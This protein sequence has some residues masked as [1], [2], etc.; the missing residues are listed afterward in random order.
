[1]LLKSDLLLLPGKKHMMLY[2]YSIFAL[3]L[4]AVI[5]YLAT[6]WIIY[7]PAVSTYHDSKQILKLETSGG[8]VI[9]AIYLPKQGSS[10]TVLMSHGNAEDL[11]SIYGVL[12]EW[13]YRDF[14]VFVYDYPGYGTSSG[15]TTEKSVYQAAHAA[16]LYLTKTLDIPANRIIIY[17]RSIGAAIATQLALTH[18]SAALILESPFV[19]A[20]RVVTK[21]PLLPFDKYNNLAK[22]K[23][24]HCPVL[25]IHGTSDEIIPFWHGQKIYQAANHPKDYFWV[26]KAGHNDILLLEA[27]MYWEKIK[28]FVDQLNQV[29][30]HSIAN[31][32]IDSTR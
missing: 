1:M 30:A 23:K 5:M 21:I 31:E 3:C 29:N 32:K 28:H 14:S 17:G 19:S 16:Y 12:H 22:I 11:G 24:I 8:D 2:I 4:L 25:V 27:D 15:K 9:S 20:S 18:P 10:Y 13:L 6:D 7:L 26:E